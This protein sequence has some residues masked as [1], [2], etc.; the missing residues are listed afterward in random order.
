MFFGILTPSYITP[1]FYFFEK[2]QKKKIFG[3]KTE[4]SSV[5]HKIRN[6]FWKIK[7]FE[8]FRKMLFLQNLSIYGKS[9]CEKERERQKENTINKQI[10]QK[11]QHF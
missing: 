1:T 6:F 10:L 2:S 7:I 8:Y 4:R 5:F 3:E 9:A 11:K